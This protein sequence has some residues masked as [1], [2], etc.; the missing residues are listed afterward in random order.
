[1]NQVQFVE[2]LGK[3]NKIRAEVVKL[4][5][6]P[7]LKEA[8]SKLEEKLEQKDNECRLTVAVC[9]QYSAGKSTLIH[10][11]TGDKTIAIGQDV[12]TSQVTTYP[13]GKNCLLADTPGIC[14]GH[15][16]HDEKSK[17][18]MASADLLVYMVTIQGF[19]RIVEPD[20]RKLV[21]GQYPEKS[22]LLMNKRNEEPEENEPNW[23][24]D[25]EAIVGGAEMLKKLRFAIIDAEDY[26][27][28]MENKEQV[29]IYKSRFNDFVTE[30]NGFVKE[31]GLLGKIVS[32][33][34]EMNVALV[35]ICED[36]AHA[37]VRDEF[38]RRQ[39]RAI[40]AAIKGCDKA[41]FEAGI[42]IRQRVKEMKHR[43]V[44]LLTDETM[45]EFQLAMDNAQ[46][47]L[48]Q[49]L[50]D[51]ILTDEI[52]AALGELSEGLEAVNID[53]TRYDETIL[54]CAKSLPNFDKF[55]TIDLSLFKSGVGE[56]GKL[57]GGVT[58]DGVVQV[59]HFFGHSFKPWG[60]TKLCNGLKAAGPWLAGLST[61]IDGAS[62]LLDKKHQQNLENTRGE[63]SSR[64]DEIENGVVAQLESMKTASGSVFVRL[65]TAYDDLVN[66]EMELERQTERKRELAAAL[67]G[68][69]ERLNE[70]RAQLAT[71]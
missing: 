5:E 10:A 26:L 68:I 35:P 69:I 4:G 37:P 42:R 30:L 67:K 12:T 53:A 11:L 46:T 7:L 34:D 9:G 41:I 47:D 21:L 71:C 3:V 36:F 18:Y 59:A 8:V 70:V 57:L 38:V 56:L 62:M 40:A 28:G 60:A 24:K 31:K 15:E 65:K 16:D 14:A 51:S 66:R 2:G 61:F 45:K 33:I 44:G 23:R 22:M 48:E 55:G 20:F 39:K 64:F 27:I 58:K 19:D 52:A 49:I 6:D 63:L 25:A 29:L 32:R 54:K 50:A 17:A 13:W 43:L 1:M